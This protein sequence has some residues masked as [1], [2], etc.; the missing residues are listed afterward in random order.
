MEKGWLKDYSES[1]NSQE[2]LAEK[3]KPLVNI[4][5][6]WQEDSL[7]LKKYLENSDGDRQDREFLLIKYKVI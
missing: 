3:L 5:S 1:T 7:K 2:N 6:K 4:F